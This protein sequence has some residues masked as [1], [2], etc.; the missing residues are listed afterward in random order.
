MI[1]KVV[2]RFPILKEMFFYGL[3]GGTSALLDTLS[4]VAFTRC[5]GWEGLISNF[6]SVNIGITV[7][8]FL[9]SYITF[10]K[11]DQILKRAL[12]FFCVGYLGLLLSTGM[13][14]LG[15]QVL[16]YHDLVVK[17]VSVFV[18]AAFQFVL[19]KL[20]TYGKVGGRKNG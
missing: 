6:L 13:L 15:V 20:I 8:F 9:N 12:S 10:K 18:V 17:L 3:I 1:R 11:T 2:K 4:Y 5:F 14:Y 19:N 7:S 16:G